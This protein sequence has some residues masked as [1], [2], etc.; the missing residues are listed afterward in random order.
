MPG[1]EPGIAAAAAAASG[2]NR[3][4]PSGAQKREARVRYGAAC[5]VEPGISAETLKQPGG[6]RVGRDN[7]RGTPVSFSIPDAWV[8]SFQTNVRHLSQQQEARFRGCVLEDSI[9]A[10]AGY[11]EQMAPTAA[12]RVTARHGDSPLMNIQ[13]LRRRIAPYP[14][15]WG[16]LIDRQDRVRTIIDPD[17]N[18]SKAASQAMRRGQDDEIVAAFFGTAYAGHDGSTAIVWPN[19]NAESVPTQPGGTVIGVSDWTYG[20][21]S[22]SSGLTISKLI[23]A[24]V[25]LLAAEGDN[26]EESYLAIGARQLGNL[27]ATTE[28]TSAEYNDLRS[29]NKANFNG[30]TFAGF[31]L[32]HSERLQKN[33]SGQT[34]VVA[35]RKSGMGLGIARD[36]E[37]QAAIRSDKRFS[38]Y[39]YADMDI[40][41]SR[42]EEAKIVEIVCA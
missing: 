3:S 33:A 25:A 36:I 35:W 30:Q 37:T 2:S 5:G 22:G 32:V 15:D 31:K 10:E 6:W 27:L 13:H 34:R 28:F 24:Q 23:S 41:A 8:S 4:R 40:G 21:G 42:L 9:H 1:R 19:G 38:T 11:M 18:Y 17:S 12:R 16:D 14:Y 20:Q 29:L 39:I 7:H 26:E